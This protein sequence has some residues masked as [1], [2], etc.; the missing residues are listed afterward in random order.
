M[1]IQDYFITKKTK[2]NKISEVICFYSSQT[3]LKGRKTISPL[4]LESE[5]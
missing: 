4:P 2:W 5:Y 3:V 1:E